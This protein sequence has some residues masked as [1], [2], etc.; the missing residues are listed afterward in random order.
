MCLFKMKM[1]F[2]SASN[3]E[4]SYVCVLHSPISTIIGEFTNIPNEIH[5]YKPNEMQLVS[6]PSQHIFDT[7][8]FIM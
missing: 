1:N 4:K 8:I 6:K 5:A 7:H 2:F 3:F